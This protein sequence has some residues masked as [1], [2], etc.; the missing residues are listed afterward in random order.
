MASAEEKYRLNFTVADG[1]IWGEEDR[2]AAI[3]AVEA[4]ASKFAAILGVN[5][6]RAWALTF[7]HMK[8]QMGGCSNC[9]DDGAVG[10]YTNGAH[11]IQFKGLSDVSSLRRRNHVVHEL[12]HAFKWDLHT[13]TG[14]DIYSELGTWRTAHPG[15]PDRFTFSGSEDTTGPN[16]GFASPQNVFTWQQSLE[17]TDA[18]EFADQ[19]VEWTFNMLETDASG[20]L[21]RNGQTRSD[22]MG[23]NM[24]FWVDLAAGR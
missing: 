16:Y 7:H 9:A 15:Y 3:A 2:A 8:F 5:A 1:M 11:E 18:E 22:M 19:F 10:G 20:A 13:K 12:G 21:T 4:V 24:L 23:S 14:I 17:G 6:G